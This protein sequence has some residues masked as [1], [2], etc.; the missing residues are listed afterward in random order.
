MVSVHGELVHVLLYVKSVTHE[1]ITTLIMNSPK[2]LT[3]YVVG[4]TLSSK[5]VMPRINDMEL[6]YR[7]KFQNRKLFTAG[8]FRIG[9]LQFLG[10]NPLSGNCL[11]QERLE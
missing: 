9:L 6:F 4:N 8:T 1:G 7:K 11:L 2:L 3:F 5:E 10:S